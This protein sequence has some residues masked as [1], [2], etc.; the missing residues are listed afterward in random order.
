M[1]FTRQTSNTNVYVNE[2]KYMDMIIFLKKI[3]G[4]NNNENDKNT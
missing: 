3:I 1:L 2:W 4:I